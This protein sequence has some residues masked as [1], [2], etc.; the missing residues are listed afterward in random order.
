MEPIEEETNDL[1]GKIMRGVGLGLS[2]LLADLGYSLGLYE[3]LAASEAGQTTK[4]IAQRTG[5]VERYVDDWLANQVAA[6][7]VGL[8][9]PVE[10]PPR[11]FLSEAQKRVFVRM[12]HPA[13][14]LGPLQGMTPM[15]YNILNRLPRDFKEGKGI[16]WSENLPVEFQVCD[17]FRKKESVDNMLKPLLSALPKHLI[18]RLVSSRGEPLLVLDVGCGTGYYLKHLTKCYPNHLFVGMDG[19]EA[20]LERARQLALNEGLTP[21]NPLFFS[22]DALSVPEPRN[23][24]GLVRSLQMLSPKC[25]IPTAFDMV[26]LI[27]TLHDLPD[28]L[29]ALQSIRSHLNSEGAL[30]V[31]ELGFKNPTL[32]SLGEPIDLLLSASAVTMCGPNGM[33]G[34]FDALPVT[35]EHLGTLATDNQYF[36]LAKHAG[37]EHVSKVAERLFLMST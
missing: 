27:D 20:S 4:E 21:N 3:A 31:Q 28:P 25:T 26:L 1:S 14:Q 11:F 29:A 10:C 24:P 8:V 30:I 12:E 35:S 32:E 23:I 5:L 7:F 37:F 22:G 15:A 13:C 36:E 19:H 16:R 9:R 33:A 17:I 34:R 2:C 18:E 6:G